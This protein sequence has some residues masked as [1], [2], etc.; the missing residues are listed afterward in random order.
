MKHKEFLYKHINLLNNMFFNLHIILYII[1]NNNKYE[2]YI[3]FKQLFNDY[4]VSWIEF[5]KNILHDITSI[6]YD[7]QWLLEP[8]TKYNT[9]ILLLY[10]K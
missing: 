1:T 2:L 5:F 8:I 9:R 3:F 10:L 7:K 6:N 4:S